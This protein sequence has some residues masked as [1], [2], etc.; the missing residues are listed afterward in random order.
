ARNVI[1][2]TA[3][4]TLDLRLVKGNDYRRQVERLVEHVRRQ[5]F[6]VTEREPTDEER[7]QYP[8]I[9]KVTRRGGYN[10]ERTRMDLPISLKVIGAVQSTSSEPIVKLPTL[11]GSLPLYVLREVLGAPSIT[12]PLA[13]YDNNQHAEDE[14]IRLQNL[15]DGIE[16]VAAIMTMD[17]R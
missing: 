3:T 16:T 2:T 12:V 8:L 14:N 6:Y 7:S 9:A 11:G 13:N 17:G 5:G 10:A 4:A 15:W 1:P